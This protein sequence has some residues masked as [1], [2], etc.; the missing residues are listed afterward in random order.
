MIFTII[1]VIFYTLFVMFL[2]E[3]FY[4]NFESERPPV[5]EEE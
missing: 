3:M 4:K 1:G 5:G 2:S